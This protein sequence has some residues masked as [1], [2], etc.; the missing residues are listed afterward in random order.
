MS[1]WNRPITPAGAR[2]VVKRVADS[3][4]RL[5]EYR[6]A[7]ELWRSLSGRPFP[8][9]LLKAERT[10]RKHGIEYTDD[11]DAPRVAK[12]TQVLARSQDVEATAAIALS[13]A[14]YSAKSNHKPVNRAGIEVLLRLP[15]RAGFGLV[16]RLM[17]TVKGDNI[18]SVR[19]VAKA[20]SLP[21]ARPPGPT[22]D[23][24]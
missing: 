18:H 14:S 17:R 23:G 8:A 13:L 21:T 19:R 22:K 5:L 10:I 6:E 1:T 24:R 12:A 20:L 3:P 9:A 15:G 11:F 7:V 16:E 2:D 4:W